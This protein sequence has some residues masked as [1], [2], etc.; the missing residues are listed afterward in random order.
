M[1]LNS[2]GCALFHQTLNISNHGHFGF[3][4][5]TTALG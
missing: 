4:I 3:H 1:P 2:G 5:L